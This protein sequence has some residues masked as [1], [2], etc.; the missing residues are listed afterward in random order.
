MNYKNNIL[1]LKMDKY[2]ISLKKDN[3]RYIQSIKYL[4]EYGV[5]NVNKFEAIDGNE[6]ELTLDNIRYKHPYVNVSLSSQY[7]LYN[8]RTKFRELPSKGA[9]GCYL[10]HISLWEKLL[11]SNNDYM[12]IFEDDILPLDNNL[13][14]KINKLVLEKD[15]F[16]VLLLGYR[17]ED[18]KTIKITDNISRCT[19]F[20]LSHSY[21]ISKKG[22]EK[23]LKYAFPIEMQ[24][25]NFIA[26]NNLLNKDFKTYYTNK[27]LFKQSNHKSSIQNYCFIC[28]INLLKD[29]HI[30]HLL[31]PS[32]FMYLIYLLFI[33]FC[34]WKR[35][36]II[37]YGKRLSNRYF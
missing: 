36:N 34:I 28:V 18:K 9:I 23:L 8:G 4:Q 15:D 32:L 2:I 22:A 27:M 35:K 25:D 11:K 19:F 10:S 24:L 29:K 33:I 26:F 30:T 37:K 17:I 31:L 21:I 3:D 12:L 13:D 6:L 20:V 16:D 14:D 5:N 1:P 7:N